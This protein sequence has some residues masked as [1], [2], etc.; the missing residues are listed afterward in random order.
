MTTI[1]SDL[2]GYVRSA[3]PA[4]HRS[5]HWAPE[6]GDD[7]IE[8]IDCAVRPYNESARNPCVDHQEGP[9]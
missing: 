7:N 6:Y 3:Y 2:Q 8:C 4:A 1:R 5:H 9:E